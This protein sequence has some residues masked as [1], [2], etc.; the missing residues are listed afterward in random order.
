MKYAFIAEHAT[1]YSVARLCEV[2][3]VGRSGYY[4]WRS[5]PESAR[6]QANRE[7]CQHIHSAFLLH[8]Q[9]YGSPRMYH[10][11]LEEGW[12]CGRHRVAR[13]M[14]QEH[15][16][17]KQARKRR[18][19]TTCQAA[20][21]RVAPN[22]LNRDFTAQ[23]PNQKWV[24]DITYIP[25]QEGWLYLAS[26]LD[27]YSRRVVGWAMDVNMETD[28]VE[29]AWQMAVQQRHPEPGLLS[30]TD[31]GSQY[32]SDSY[33]QALEGAHCQVSMSRTGNCWDNAVMES[34]HASLKG[35]CADHSFATRQEARSAVFEYIEV[36]Y[37]R[38]RIHS[39]LGY[40]SPLE[41][42]QSSGH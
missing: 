15:L 14:R 41:F 13:L 39:S 12:G 8:R 3:K 37:N 33:W 18:P 22:L 36:W 1:Q 19:R 27:V 38:Q 31:R 23:G 26:I 30:H 25:T 11:L 28:L 34:F 2:L 7:L 20:G 35:E 24:A 29:R 5:R 40:L 32:T 4:A 21:A 9:V 10:A 16:V 17:A 6:A 42:E